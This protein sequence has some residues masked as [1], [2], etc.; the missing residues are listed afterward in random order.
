MKKTPGQSQ[1][2]IDHPQ[3]NCKIN[4][5][6]EAMV[7]VDVLHPNPKLCEQQPGAMPAQP[8]PIQ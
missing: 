4:Y 6:S 5:L 1:G 7:V 8:F 2:K 3:V